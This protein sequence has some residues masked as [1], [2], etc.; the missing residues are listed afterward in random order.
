M[1]GSDER[2]DIKGGGLMWWARGGYKTSWDCDHIKCNILKFSSP[3]FFF[4]Q[5]RR[6]RNY[7]GL[8]N[9]VGPTLSTFDD[10]NNDHLLIQT[11]K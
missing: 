5:T 9:Y 2:S 3:F 6:V 10:G 1:N 8:T 4:N 7:V 11:N